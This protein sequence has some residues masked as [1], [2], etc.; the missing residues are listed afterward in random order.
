[1]PGFD[2]R[3]AAQWDACCSD[4]TRV[5]HAPSWQSC[6]NSSAVS[7]GAGACCE[8]GCCCGALLA[9]C[10][11]RI[12]T[13]EVESAAGPRCSHRSLM[14]HGSGTHCGTHFAALACVAGVLEAAINKAEAKGALGRRLGSR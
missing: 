9:L 2:E 7:S 13:S 10:L 12:H 1:M 6:T 5:E 14:L 4:V 8:V 3:E 11:L